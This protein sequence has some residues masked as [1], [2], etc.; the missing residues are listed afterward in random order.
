MSNPTFDFQTLCDRGAVDIPGTPAARVYIESMPGVDGQFVQT[1]GR[2][3]RRIAVRGELTASD[4][5][6]A[7][8]HAALKALIRQRQ[9]MVGTIAL[10]VGTDGHTYYDCVLMSYRP[11]PTRIT[12]SAGSYTAVVPVRAEVHQASP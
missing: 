10:Y 6:P 11:G 9:Q 7:A 5:T 3:G 1:H 12:A 8:A 4:A 2:G